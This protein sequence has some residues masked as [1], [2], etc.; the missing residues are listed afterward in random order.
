[1]KIG[2]ISALNIVVACGLYHGHWD[3]I[4]SMVAMLCDS[5]A[6][7]LSK[8]NAFQSNVHFCYGIIC[9]VPSFLIN[10]GFW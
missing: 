1:V 4:I 3:G 7:Q 10:C 8:F 5:E 6:I 9:L 2:K